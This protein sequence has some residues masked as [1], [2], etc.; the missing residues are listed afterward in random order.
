MT[1]PEQPA[2]FFNPYA[3][4]I[5]T[6]VAIA[7]LADLQIR[8]AIERGEFDDVPGSGQPIDLS[9]S[10]DPDWW[11]KRLMRREGFVV[12]PSSIQLRKDDA[13][14]DALL[15]GCS[16]ENEVRRELD[17]F[18][19]RVIRARY[20]LS[21]GPPLVTMPRDVDAAVRAWADRRAARAAAAR[22]RRLAHEAGHEPHPRRWW[23]QH[24]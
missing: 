23:R 14:L 19:R 20:D 11:F 18:N 9:D 8:R 4:P 24:R 16:S 7:L 22:E 10:G 12:L 17:D 1:T 13:A 15:D 21:G 2:A 5:D 6:E 3:M